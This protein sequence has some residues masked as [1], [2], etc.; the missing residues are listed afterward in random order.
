M[1][2]FLEKADNGN[3]CSRSSRTPGNM[4][5]HKLVVG[6]ALGDA[7]TD[8]AELT[9]DDNGNGESETGNGVF[10]N[11][12]GKYADAKGERA[13]MKVVSGG[14]TQEEEREKEGEVGS[15]L[16]AYVGKHRSLRRKVDQLLIIQGFYKFSLQYA[17]S[18]KNKQVITRD[19]FYVHQ[20]HCSQCGQEYTTLQDMDATLL[21]MVICSSAYRRVNFALQPE[22]VFPVPIS[23]KSHP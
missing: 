4:C 18:P 21:T 9:A 6:L 23:H 16:S 15:A 1:L 11:L 12:W 2:F 22:H 17:I 19:K 3:P 8:P 20:K 7:E 14:V 5:V 13:R 10:Q